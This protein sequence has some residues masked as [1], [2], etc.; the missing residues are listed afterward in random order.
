MHAAVTEEHYNEATCAVEDG[1]TIGQGD[2]TDTFKDDNEA[3]ES[4]APRRPHSHHYCCICSHDL[5][6]GE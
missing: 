3:E 1:D 5:K 4:P 2:A 6:L